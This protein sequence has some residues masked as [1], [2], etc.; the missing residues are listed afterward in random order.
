MILTGCSSKNNLKFETINVCVMPKN[1][2]NTDLEKIKINLE[3]KAIKKFMD[4]H[5]NSSSDNVV[6]FD[7]FYYNLEEMRKFCLRTKMTIDSKEKKK[8]KS[9]SIEDFCYKAG[10]SRMADLIQLAVKKGLQQ[11][12]FKKFPELKDTD[13]SI[14]KKNIYN[15]DH[16]KPDFD[17]DK[18]TICLDIEADYY[19]DDL[20]LLSID[21]NFKNRKFSYIEDFNEFKAGDS[22]DQ[23]CKNLKIKKVLNGKTLYSPLEQTAWANFFA[24]NKENLKISANIHHTTDTKF[25]N[26]KRFFSIAKIKYA[27]KKIDNINIKIEKDASGKTKIS[28]LMGRQKSENIYIPFSENY[29][30]IKFIKSKRQLEIFINDKFTG[31]FLSSGEIIKS[32]SIPLNNKT[33][34]LGIK[35]KEL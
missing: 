3:R 26:F 35:I 4:K 13:W 12:L 27:N 14:I 29:N 31:A 16:S 21:S 20:A 32:I 33:E 8:K 6:F 18:N 7:R 30:S 24:G 23:F 34:L 28:I 1:A 25:W 9:I 5:K 11:E 22:G 2:S 19:P 17:L 15:I 10:N